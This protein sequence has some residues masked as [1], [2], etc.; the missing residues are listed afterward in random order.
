M[1]RRKRAIVKVHPC[2]GCTHGDNGTTCDILGIITEKAL[3]DCWSL[4]YRNIHIKQPT[5]IHHEGAYW[6]SKDRNGRMG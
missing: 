3:K 1:P 5:Y 4:G 2:R 6:S